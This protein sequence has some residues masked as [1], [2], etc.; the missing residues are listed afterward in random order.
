M[1]GG[2]PARMLGA[3]LAVP[4]LAAAALGAPPVSLVTGDNGR[5][6]RAAPAARIVVTLPANPSTGF[7]WKLLAPLDRRILA[8]VSHR[9]V[10]PKTAV[11]GAPGKEVWRFR[12]VGKGRFALRLGYLRSWDPTNV[13]RRFRVDFRVS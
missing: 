12:A 7:R 1:G 6:V 8:L 13:E 9:Y 10:A 2:P 5:I 11:V 4:L 3:M